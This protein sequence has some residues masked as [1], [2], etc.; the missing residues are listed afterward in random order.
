[1]SLTV[2]LRRSVALAG[3]AALMAGIAA[4]DVTVK[5]GSNSMKAD[6]FN[7]N[8]SRMQDF[9]YETGAPK[10]PAT[11]TTSTGPFYIQRTADSATATVLQAVLGGS[12][13]PVVEIT[14]TDGPDNGTGAATVWRVENAVVNNYGTYQGVEPGTQTENFDI[15]GSTVTYSYFGVGSNGQRSKSPTTTFTWKSENPY[16]GYGYAG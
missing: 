2:F 9:D 14:V 12:T 7:M 16:G 8:L 10:E 13:F 1:M 5:L 4:A 11:F 15:S 6:S 3:A